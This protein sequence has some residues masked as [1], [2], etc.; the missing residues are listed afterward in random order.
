MESW[1][2]DW[3]TY[4]NGCN[5]PTK[6]QW[7]FV[8][9]PQIRLADLFV[10]SVPFT[11][12]EALHARNFQLGKNPMVRRRVFPI[13]LF[14][15]FVLENLARRKS[16][17]PGIGTMVTVIYAM[18]TAATLPS[19]PTLWRGSRDTAA[20]LCKQAQ[21]TRVTETTVTTWTQRPNLKAPLPV[22]VS[23]SLSVMNW[24]VFGGQTVFVLS[25]S[26]DTSKWK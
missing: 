11:V 24:T 26:F 10:A 18:G 7:N 21:V 3:L 8:E 16:T 17:V 4:A 2:R 15:P 19:V 20:C 13:L 25:S 12:L 23:T 14:N 9:A 5:L 6:W 22:D 1:K